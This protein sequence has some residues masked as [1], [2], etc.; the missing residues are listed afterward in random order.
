MNE[1]DSI[2]IADMSASLQ[3]IGQ[4]LYRIE[5]L[6][7]RGSNDGLLEALNQRDVTITELQARVASLEGRMTKEERKIDNW[8]PPGR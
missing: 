5:D 3:L 8:A 4:A 1:L 6:I 2:N 7:K